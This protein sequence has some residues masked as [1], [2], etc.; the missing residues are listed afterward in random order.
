MEAALAALS[1][2]RV[3]Q[4]V[5]TVVPVEENSR[6]LGIMPAVAADVMGAKIV[7]SIP[8]NETTSFQR[9]TER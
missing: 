2:G 6:Y 1:T 5:R 3:R 8:V 9:T 4:P 7:I